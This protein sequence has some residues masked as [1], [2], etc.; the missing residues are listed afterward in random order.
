MVVVLPTPLTADHHDH[1]GFGPGRRRRT[2]GH[3]YQS[4]NL[5][6]QG[7]FEGLGVADVSRSSGD[8][9]HEGHGGLD[10]HV[11]SDQQFFKFFEQFRVYWRLPLN[12]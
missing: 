5:F 4:Q 10:A 1:M 12:S 8:A 3:V 9:F 6:L 2:V 7:L 11:G